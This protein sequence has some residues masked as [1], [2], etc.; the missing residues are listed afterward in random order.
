[1]NNTKPYEKAGFYTKTPIRPEGPKDI[2][3]GQSPLLFEMFVRSSDLAKHAGNDIEKTI[4]V[5]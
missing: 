1:M 2:S 3:D 4:P 5:T